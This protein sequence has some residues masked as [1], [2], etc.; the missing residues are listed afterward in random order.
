MA[1]SG[2]QL[3]VPPNT[4]DVVV[5]IGVSFGKVVAKV[6]LLAMWL[7]ALYIHIQLVGSLAGSRS[8]LS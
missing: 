2:D 6:L 4:T 1:L 5:E 3:I 8:H 7:E